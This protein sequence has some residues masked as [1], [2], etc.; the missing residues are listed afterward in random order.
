MLKVLR[1]GV[2]GDGLGLSP[3]RPSIKI[4]IKTHFLWLKSNN[5]NLK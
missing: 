2:D 5:I 1:F 3:E 4:Y